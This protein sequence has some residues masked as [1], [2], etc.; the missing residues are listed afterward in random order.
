MR[1]IIAILAFVFATVGTASVVNAAPV[2]DCT[3]WKEMRTDALIVSSTNNVRVVAQDLWYT[4]Y[5]E[6]TTGLTCSR[7]FIKSSNLT[8]WQNWQGEGGR[9]FAYLLMPDNTPYV[10]SDARVRWRVSLI[11]L[12][13]G[14]GTLELGV[15]S[16][17]EI[18]QT[19]QLDVSVVNK[20]PR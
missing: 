11:S 10:L 5:A 16:R 20:P 8:I 18:K 4:L 6:P 15:F 9:S 3:K 2:A 19:R 14:V 17:G 1:R 7:F 13:E 12:P